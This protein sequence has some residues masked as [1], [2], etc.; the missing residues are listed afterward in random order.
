MILSWFER[1][2]PDV[3][4][5]TTAVYGASTFEAAQARDPGCRSPLPTPSGERVRTTVK[6]GLLS[7]ALGSGMLVTTGPPATA[8]PPQ[9]PSQTSQSEHLGE[10]DEI[11]GPL[12]TKR[13]A[14]REEGL[15]SV[16]EGKAKVE[17]KG[18]SDVVKVGSTQSETPT[19]SRTAAAPREDQY[20]QLSREGT[21]RIFV[22]LAEFGNQRDARFPDKDIN[23]ATVGPVTYEGPLHNAIPAPDR[24]KDNSTVWQA[25]YDRKHYENLYFGR[26]LSK[27]SVAEYYEIQSSGRYSVSG[28]VTDWVKVP[29]NEA[30]YGRSSDPNEDA[31][32]DDPNVCGD[33]VCDNSVDLV[34]DAVNVWEAGQ[35][36]K[37]RTAAQIAA[38]L[39]TFDVQDRYDYDGDGNFSEPDG[40]IDHFQVV[41]AGGDES[42]GDPQQGED[43]IWA[44]RSYAY[45]GSAGQTGPAF[46]KLGGS[47]IGRTGLWV[48]DYT[49]QPENGG[50]SVFAHEYGHDLGLPDHYDTN[51][52]GNSVEYWNLMAQSRL[53]GVGEALGT[54]AGDLSAWDKLQLGWLDYETVLANQA[55]TL[56][57]G[58]HEYNSAKAQAV[59]VVLPDKNVT[60]QLGAP[61]SGAAQYWS[62]SGN[63]ITT[64]LTSAVDLTGA[65][66]AAFGFQARYDIEEG[67][68]YLYVQASKD[69]GA[70]WTNLDGTVGGAPF[71]RDGSGNPAL[72]GTQ[73]AWVPASVPLTAYKG[74]KPL[75]RFQYRTDGGVAPIGFFA[76]RLTLTRNG[77][78]TVLDG[79]ENAAT[80]TW[81]ANG[82]TRRGAS[83][84]QAYDHYYLASNRSAVRQDKY[85]QTGPYNFGFG[86]ALPDKVEHFSYEQGLL[87]S[88]WDTSYADNNTTEHPGN[89]LVLPIDAHPAPIYNLQGQAW[90]S[91]IQVYDA[92]FSL[93]AARSFTLHVNG[94]ANYIRGQA[95]APVFDDSKQ[96]WYPELPLVGVKVPNAGV[97][98]QV[99]AQDG[100]SMTVKLD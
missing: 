10:P 34:R 56:E 38:E 12:E 49:M 18:N 50:M 90:R 58:P 29:F 27:E 63:A 80:S 91:R 93:T 78:T 14:L 33:V 52:G 85:L 7:L 40:Y 99:L 65:T 60:R 9:A 26:G 30:R 77:S 20:V 64:T 81:V 16:L 72:T 21:D 3:A 95:A 1:T 82:F 32:G 25:D 22:V 98:M 83:F 51:G 36:A 86:A 41:H 39:K 53:N 43:A 6:A 75:V 42:D 74:T 96:Y 47:Q 45:P 87:V 4:N 67:Y 61:Y 57:L 31:P 59:A 13:R 15:T 5:T 55:T 94:Q 62:G 92:P 23:P 2:I 76:D 44:H 35:R 66:T 68:D 97:R 84:T 8:A 100:T 89:G 28:T 17:R 73:T 69:G 46:N 54:R 24:T 37:G 11:A 71:P 88:Y 48:G 19:A 79:A 70:T